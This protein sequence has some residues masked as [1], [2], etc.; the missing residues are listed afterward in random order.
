[1]KYN[2]RKVI[3]LNKTRKVYQNIDFKIKIAKYAIKNDIANTVKNFNVNKNTIKLWVKQYKYGILEE[4]KVNN[5]VNKE[6]NNQFKAINEFQKIVSDLL[7]V[8]LYKK[9]NSLRTKYN[10]PTT[11]ILDLLKML[12]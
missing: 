7:D 11:T 3:M 2:Y 12:V 5:K 10:I 4:K 9:L 1:M 6:L 8:N